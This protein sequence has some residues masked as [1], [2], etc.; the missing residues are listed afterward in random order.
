MISFWM[1]ITRLPIIADTAPS[2]NMMKSITSR[3]LQPPAVDASISDPTPKI[4]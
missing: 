1:I 3:R 4:V 2:N